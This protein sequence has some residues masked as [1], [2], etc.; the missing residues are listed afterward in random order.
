ME[1]VHGREKSTAIFNQFIVKLFIV[2]RRSIINTGAVKLA[3]TAALL[4][5]EKEVM[6]GKN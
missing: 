5:P 2:K 4:L 6:A 1:Q 3:L